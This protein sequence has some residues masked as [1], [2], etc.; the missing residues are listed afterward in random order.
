M[1]TLINHRLI[2]ALMLILMTSIFT[3]ALAQ[4]KSRLAEKV[5][6]IAMQASNWEIP[7][8]KASFIIYRNV[9]ALKIEQGGGLAILKDVDFTNGTIEFD[10]EP[11]DA[12]KSPFVTCYFRQQDKNEGECFYLRVGRD[13]NI[14]RNDAV[15]YTPILMGVNLWDMMPHYQGPAQLNNKEWNHIRLVVNGKQMRAYVNNSRRP[16]LEIPYLEGNTTHGKFAF[17]GYGMYANLVIKPDVTDDLPA[18]AAPDL[19]NH[20]ANYIRRWLLSGPLPLPEG[21]EL[22]GKDLPKDDIRWDSIVAER[23]GLVNI[24]RRLGGGGDRRYVWLKATIVAD[25]AQKNM[26]QLGFSDEVWIFLNKRMIQVDKNLFLQGMRKNPDGRCAIENS[27]FGINLKAGENE[28]LIGLSN[29]F[30]G[31]GIIAR[32]ES[33]EGIRLVNESQR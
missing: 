10:V 21:R 32:L 18:V 5:Q 23:E 29:D 12:V 13:D 17:E 7:S 6:A 16:V 19:T 3:A 20:D 28:L 26:I 27:S 4:K 14:V 25:A 11:A 24:T 33:M 15:Q 22:S 31:W 1:K 2:A 30:Y 9:P 8:Q